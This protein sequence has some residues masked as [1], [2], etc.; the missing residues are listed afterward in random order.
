MLASNLLSSHILLVRGV[1]RHRRGERLICPVTIIL[2]EQLRA[3]QVEFLR[4]ARLF[5]I[6]M[7]I[8]R[9]RRDRWSFPLTLPVPEALRLAEAR[10]EP[11]SSPQRL[12]LTG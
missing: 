5:L 3:L 12:T 2:V 4:L 10:S 8:G 9:Q 11:A 1:E 7:R 6:G